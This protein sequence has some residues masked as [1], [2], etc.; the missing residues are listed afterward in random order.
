MYLCNIS[1][2]G[3]LKNNELVDSNELTIYDIQSKTKEWEKKYLH[4]DFFNNINNITKIL[5]KK[6][7]AIYIY[8]RYL[9]KIFV[10]K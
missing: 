4:P 10:Q 7:V 5:L 1:E 6:Y 8:S 9:V 3:Y 2:Y